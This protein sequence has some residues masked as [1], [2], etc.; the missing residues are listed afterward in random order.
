MA[1]GAVH[2]RCV[3]SGRYLEKLPNSTIA[4]GKRRNLGLQHLEALVP[5]LHRSVLHLDP[6]AR[7]RLRLKGRRFDVAASLKGQFD[8]AHRRFS[9]RLNPEDSGSGPNGASVGRLARA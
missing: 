8:E 1:A 6:E 5:A 4:V 2:N 9:M 7:R 3:V